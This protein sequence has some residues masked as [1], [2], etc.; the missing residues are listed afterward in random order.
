M[1]A[2]RAFGFSKGF[3]DY[4]RNDTIAAADMQ[5]G[6]RREW[7]R[8]AMSNEELRMQNAELM[9]NKRSGVPYGGQKDDGGL[10]NLTIEMSMEEM[11]GYRR[12][13]FG[14]LFLDKQGDLW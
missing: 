3:L 4:A 14:C 6:R 5:A 8:M 7:H 12:W 11:K 1:S 2:R 10:V 13:I 9:I